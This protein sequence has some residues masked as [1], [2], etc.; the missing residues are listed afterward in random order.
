MKQN[1]SLLLMRHALGSIDLSD[2]EETEMTEPQ[3]RDYCAAIHAVFPRLENDIKKLLYQQTLWVAKESEGWDQ[4][5]FGRG[6]IEGMAML[7][8]KWSAAHHEHQASSTNETFDK[9]NPLAE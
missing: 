9:H 2:A 1:D 5:T 6:V 3:R 8:E 4:V 7:L